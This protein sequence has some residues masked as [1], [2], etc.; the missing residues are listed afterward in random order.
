M[1]VFSETKIVPSNAID[2]NGHVNNITYLQWCIDLAETHWFAKAP[3]EIT[4]KYFWVVLEHHISYKN[5]AFEGEE[6]VLSTWVTTAEGVKSERHYT[7]TRKSDNTTLVTAHT[8]WCYVAL[9]SQRPTRIPQ[10]IRTLFL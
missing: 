6:L 5:P 2:A 7:I 4:E 10:E 8:L 9:D 1:K 3:K